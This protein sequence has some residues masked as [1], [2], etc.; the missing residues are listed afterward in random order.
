VL[1]AEP[2]R[3]LRWLGRFLVPGLMDGEHAF[4]IEPIAGGRSRFTQS[5]RFSGILV[6]FL[7]GTLRKTELGFEQ[8]NGALKQ[9]VEAGA[10]RDS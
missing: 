2:G 1:A 5:E 3:E 8:M 9:R 10:A 6:A 4:R 7:K